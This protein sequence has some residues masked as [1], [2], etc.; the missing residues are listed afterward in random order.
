MTRSCENEVKRSD[1]SV[2]IDMTEEN[3]EW[4]MKKETVVK[5]SL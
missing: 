3:D 2:V 5:V 4:M 1:V